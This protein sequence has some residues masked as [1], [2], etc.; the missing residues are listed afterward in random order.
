MKMMYSED[1]PHIFDSDFELKQVRK[2]DKGNIYPTIMYISHVISLGLSFGD[3]NL[4]EF[5]KVLGEDIW[6]DLYSDTPINQ[7]VRYSA[8]HVVNHGSK[9]KEHHE[10]R[11]NEK[12]ITVPDFMKLFTIKINP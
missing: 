4:D 2:I 7:F 9:K 8:F 11:D 6:S 3:S 1:I 10:V 12:I 5:I